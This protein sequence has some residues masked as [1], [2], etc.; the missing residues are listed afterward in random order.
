MQ[1]HASY[2]F[3]GTF[4]NLA[5]RSFVGWMYRQ[6]SPVLVLHVHTLGRR[7]RRP[8]AASSK[9]DER[10]LHREC[11]GGPPLM[12]YP[13]LQYLATRSDCTDLVLEVSVSVYFLTSLKPWP[14]QYGMGSD[15]PNPCI[16]ARE[17]H[18]RRFP[19]AHVLEHT[20]HEV[21]CTVRGPGPGLG[22]GDFRYSGPRMTSF[23]RLLCS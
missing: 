5:P 2:H 1:A 3:L 10:A 16:L 8:S 11:Y 22:Q 13:S 21:P 7:P 12:C 9:L 4:W 18:W 20:E 19:N 17:E 23:Q 15:G 14:E 6:R